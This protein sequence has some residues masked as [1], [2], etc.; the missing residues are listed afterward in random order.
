MAGDPFEPQD[1]TGSEAARLPLDEGARAHGEDHPLLGLL[2]AI[3]QSVLK[4]PLIR[5]ALER[6]ES[7]A[8]WIVLGLA[9][10]VAGLVGGTPA[11][12]LALLVALP[13]LFVVRFLASR[14]RD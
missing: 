5:S 1:R 14:R 8:P 3:G 4:Q 6:P 11:V 9:V 13:A 12:F 7:A 10:G 2:E